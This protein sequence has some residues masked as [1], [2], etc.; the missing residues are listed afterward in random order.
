MQSFNFLSRKK[1]K[2]TTKLFFTLVFILGQ[3]F[4]VFSQP[5]SPTLPPPP[6]IPVDQGIL[7]LL[8]MGVC[9]GIYII[10]KHRP[11]KNLD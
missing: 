7:G 9:L 4:L 10:K 8:A 1:M 5:P 11:V 3:N 6:D 2:I